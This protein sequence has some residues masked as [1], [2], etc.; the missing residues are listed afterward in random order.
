MG[1]LRA[2][3]SRRSQ[4]ARPDALHGGATDPT[5]DDVGKEVHESFD[6]SGTLAD[7]ASPRLKELRQEQRAARTRIMARFADLMH[8]YA[9][10][11]QD[12]FV[13]EREGRFVIPVRADAHL[14]FPGIVHGTS[15]SGGT[16]FVEPRAVI[17]MG[18]R[19]KVLEGEV[20]REE[21]AITRACRRASASSY[22]A[23]SERPR[24]WRGSTS[25][26]PSRSSP[27]SRTFT[28]CR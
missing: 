24:R 3:A 14:R 17:P 10:L 15:G 13:T 19:L 11:L 12:Q 16:L 4:G 1:A 8:R 21:E 9:E 5:L 6:A 18:N 27:R 2:P 25:A 26:P 22:R 7:H 28:S 23:S 20:A